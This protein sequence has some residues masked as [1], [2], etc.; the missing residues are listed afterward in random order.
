MR[1]ITIIVA[2]AAGLSACG[3]TTGEQALIGGGVG[4]G[5]AAVLGSNPLVGAA[6]GAGGNMLYCNQNPSNC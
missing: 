6:V 5:T 4:A 3:D 2:A 1:R